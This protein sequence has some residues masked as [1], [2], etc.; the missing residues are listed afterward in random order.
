M[1]DADAFVPDLGYLSDVDVPTILAAFENKAA[2]LAEL[3]IPVCGDFRTG[4]LDSTACCYV[5]AEI[6]GLPR[7]NTWL[8]HQEVKQRLSY[9]EWPD[10]D[11]LQRSDQ[12]WEHSEYS[13]YVVAKAFVDL[14]LEYNLAIVFS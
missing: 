12:P 7:S 14:C 8:T 1:V 4:W 5:I 11:S 3:K 6:A 13:R 2:E 9:A 10:F